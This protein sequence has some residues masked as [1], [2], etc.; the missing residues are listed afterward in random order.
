MSYV[1]AADRAAVHLHRVRSGHNATQAA[2]TASLRSSDP[3][4][5]RK[6]LAQYK[7]VSEVVKAELARSDEEHARAARQLDSSSDYANLISSSPAAGP[8]DALGRSNE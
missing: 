8:P 7:M 2:L 4:K 6:G 1:S 5:K 3:A